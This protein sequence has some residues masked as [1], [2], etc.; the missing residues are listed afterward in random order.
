MQTAVKQ[1]LQSNFLHSTFLPGASLNS[2]QE[3]R[4]LFI[5]SAPL[6]IF[7]FSLVRAASTDGCCCGGG[8]ENDGGDGGDQ[9]CRIS[10]LFIKPLVWLQGES[11]YIAYKKIPIYISNFSPFYYCVN[12]GIST[13]KLSKH[14][15]SWME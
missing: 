3:I 8:G 12:F 4:E 15:V 2:T 5:K 10:D 14:S 13:F 9:G 6:C 11:C 7:V 1:V